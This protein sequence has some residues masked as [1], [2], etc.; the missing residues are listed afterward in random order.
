MAGRDGILIGIDIGTSGCK[1]SA[2]DTEGHVLASGSVS[3]ATQYPRPG[4]MEQDP[5]DWWNACCAALRKIFASGAVDAA[6]VSAVG[7]DGMSWSCV[8]LDADGDVLLPSYIW[9]DR[10][11]DAQAAQLKERFGE[12]ALFGKSGNPVDA[13]YVTPKILWM[14]QHEAEAYKRCRSLLQCNGYIVYCLTGE[15][16]QDFS[17]G[18]AY[19]FFDMKTGTYD[20]ALAERMG[21]DVSILP[22]IMPCHGVAGVVTRTASEETGLPIGIPVVAGGLDAA[23]QTFGAGVVR[24]G[25][26]QEQGGQAGGMSILMKE[27]R[28]HEKLIL[29]YHVLPDTWLLQGGS[30]GGGSL[31]W[32]EREFGA[33]ER[34]EAADSGRGVFEVLS[35]EAASVRPGA[36]GLLY[37]PYMAGERSPIW[38]SDARGL[39]FGLGYDKTRAHLVRAVM[40][41]VGYSLEHNLRTAREAG[42]EASLLYSV[43]GAANSC[44]WTQIKADITGC[45]IHVPYSDHATT[46]GAA[47]L[48]GIGSGLYASFEE[49]AARC[50]RIE[51]THE[52]NMKTHALYQEYMA[53]YLD[54]LS[55]VQPYFGRVSRLGRMQEKEG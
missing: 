48:A 6:D 25:Q 32:F 35:D 46:L 29:S 23:V 1:V 14:Q 55:G 7:I 22:P 3:Y 40:E 13:A 47:M 34:A 16:T 28:M 53:L 20:T 51:R 52:P 50:V 15:K 42:A 41:G 12:K 30:V 45:E 37:M 39:F 33:Q 5:R 19:H 11:S 44:V 27:P 8:A 21:V 9:M 24:E 10:R 26:T 18:Y 36:D 43:G 4:H 2:F 49:A 31:R 38:D 54:V 17:Q